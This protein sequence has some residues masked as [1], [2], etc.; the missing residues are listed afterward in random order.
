M[1]HFKDGSQQGLSKKKLVSTSFEMKYTSGEGWER[2]RLAF[3]FANT[4]VTFVKLPPDHPPPP[5]IPPLQCFITEIAP[6][7]V[8]GPGVEREK[9]EERQHNY[10]DKVLAGSLLIGSFS[11]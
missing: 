5:L 3:S 1:G 8:S 11:R 10:S 6:G 9:I 4:Q 2:P 7:V